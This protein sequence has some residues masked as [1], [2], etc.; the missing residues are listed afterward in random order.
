MY[1]IPLYVESIYSNAEC[2]VEIHDY[3]YI[4]I[5]FIWY[6]YFKV[7]QY[8]IVGRALGIKAVWTQ[9]FSS[10]TTLISKLF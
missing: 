6:T 2:S 9:H 10:L 8:E 7:S 1:T 4:C 5:A 3:S